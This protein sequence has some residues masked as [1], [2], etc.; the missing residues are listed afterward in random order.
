M[1]IIVGLG[2]PGKEYENTPHNAGFET[3]DYFAEK[4]NFPPFEFSKIFN[5]L[6]SKKGDIILVK[7]HTF[8]NASGPSVKRILDKLPEDGTREVVI[9]HDDIDL[10]LGNYKISKNRGSA[11][12]KGI[13]SIIKA[14]ETKDFT[15][16]RIGVSKTKKPDVLKKFGKKDR[17]TLNAVFEEI[18]QKIKEGECM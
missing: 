5:A 15:R 12:H 3:L 4:N 17:E 1:T 11:G 10:P 14:L 9:I 2:N 13:E 16:V 18:S 8:M 7:P 6:I